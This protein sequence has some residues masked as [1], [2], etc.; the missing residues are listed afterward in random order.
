MH[1]P[2]TQKAHWL[3]FDPRV[4]LS[5]M[6][7]RL[8]RNKWTGLDRY[9]PGDSRVNLADALVKCSLVDVTP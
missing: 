6:S 5:P 3:F 1:F 8:K 4:N 9:L 7:D 2:L